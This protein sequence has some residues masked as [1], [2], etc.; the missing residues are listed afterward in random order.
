[1]KEFVPYYLDILYQMHAYNDAKKWLSL[2]HKRVIFTRYLLKIGILTFRIH[3]FSL[4]TQLS[5]TYI[6][7]L[8]RR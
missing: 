5:N 7:S 3:I 4:V 8:F 2:K 1:M 6:F